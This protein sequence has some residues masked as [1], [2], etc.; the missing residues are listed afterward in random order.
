MFY[1][2]LPLKSH[3]GLGILKTPCDIKL[4]NEFIYVLSRYK[5]F[6]YAFTYDFTQAHNTAISSISK[7]L[8][9]PYA[10]CIDGSGQFIIS[11]YRKNA[12]YISNQQGELV[13]AITDSVYLPFGVT[14]DSK[15]RILVVS[16]NHSLLIF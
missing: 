6:L 12:I 1:K 3:F 4:T 9:W 5:P 15:G 10:F 13:H 7:H 11:D 2:E 16:H 14:L 8:K